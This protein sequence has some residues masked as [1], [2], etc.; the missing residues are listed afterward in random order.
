MPRRHPIIWIP[1]LA[2]MIAGGDDA[3]AGSDFSTLLPNWAVSVENTLRVEQYETFGDV[4]ATPYPR[5]GG[6][7]FNDFSLDLARRSSPF[8]IFS[9]QLFGTYNA[10]EYRGEEEGLVVERGKLLWEKGDTGIPFRAEIGDFFANQSFRTLQRALKG[11]QLE[12]QP[13]W[14]GGQLHSIQLFSGQTGENYRAVDD[15]TDLYTGA[16]W[17]A[18]SESVGAFTLIALHNF[19]EGDTDAG[20]APRNQIVGSA[21]WERDF[22]WRGQ[23]LTL[24]GEYARIYGAHDG[25]GVVEKDKA[26]SGLFLEARG[27]SRS[28]PLSLRATFEQYGDDFRPNGA[29]ITPDQRKIEAH[30]GW[31]FAGGQR[32][33]ARLQSFRDS[34]KSANPLDTD[35]AGLTLSGSLVDAV[36]LAGR[37][38]GFVQERENRDQSTDSVT[39]ALNASLSAPLAGGLTGRTGLLLTE[40][41]NVGDG[42]TTIGRQLSLVV[43]YDFALSGIRG[44]LS[45]GVTLRSNT[46]GDGDRDDINPTIGVTLENER[47]QLRLFHNF[48]VQ[49]IRAA[50]GTDVE[51]QQTTFDYAYSRGAHRIGLDANWFARDPDRAAET[52]AYRVSLFWTVRF[53]R[54]AARRVPRPDAPVPDTPLPD[55]Q[56]REEP[57]RIDLRDLAPGLALGPL[58]D[59]LARAGLP[60]PTER[61]GLLIYETRLLEDIN[62]RQRLGLVHRDGK[63]AKS[64]LVVDFTDVG[65]VDSVFQTFERVREILFKRYGPPERRIEEGAFVGG[66]GAGLA[67]DLANGRF[68]RLIEWRTPTGRLRFGIP[69]RADGQI[70]IEIVHAARF[71]SGLRG[72]WSIEALR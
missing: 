61:P 27:R 41:E 1:L 20:L 23:R 7:L 56:L 39:R 33:R 66:L 15:G 22:V 68:R 18:E 50:G 42:V 67:A 34:L 29:A 69:N 25:A 8:E 62:R 58:R 53:D 37:I 16:S 47:H 21:A 40:T 60:R 71:A 30:A 31:T 59:L 43:D 35:L 54:A 9:G 12:L 11:V 70:R 17:L 14:G 46:G 38:D 26:D 51:T 52:D 72:D 44:S 3:R 65:D 36:G 4:S 5:E 13:E 19:R 2:A 55:M 28:L 6:Q 49:D 64:V 63:L 10:S 24:E 45:P 32:L 57:G 48:L